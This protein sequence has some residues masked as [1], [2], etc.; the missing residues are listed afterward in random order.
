MRFTVSKFYI[1][2]FKIFVLLVFSIILFQGCLP[3]ENSNSSNGTNAANS[4]RENTNSMTD[5]NAGSTN[6]ASPY[7]AEENLSEEQVEQGRLNQ[8]WKKF[9]QLDAPTEKNQTQNTE[10]WSDV[11][12]EKVNNQKQ[13][14]PLS[15]DAQGPSVFR[16]QLLLDRTNF[17]PGIMDGKWGKN[18][19][20]AVYWLQKSEG[21]PAHGQVDRQTYERM[22]QLAG[23]P[24]RLVVEY[25]LTEKDVKGPFE[26]IPGDI[27][28]KAKMDCMCYESLE[29]QLA[30]MFHVSPA[31]LK[32]LNSKVTLN[33]LKAGDSI[34]V[35]NLP[36]PM[37]PG[38]SKPENKPDKTVAR[39]VVSDG[40]HYVHGLDSQGKLVVH[41]PSTLGSEYNP[42]P[43]G[44]YSITAI[45]HDP[46]WHYQP[47]LLGQGKGQD[48]MIPPGPN[49]AVGVIWMDLSKPHFGIHGT[50]APETIGYTTSSGCVRLTNWDA[51]DLGARI[52]KGTPVEFRDTANR[53]QESENSVNQNTRQ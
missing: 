48:A 33:D 11:T 21:L 13:Y 23:N 35:P 1:G 52:Q 36:S 27:Y 28:E 15:G 31:L 39:I 2:N 10:K 4:T 45:A 3:P 25:K 16:A 5:A 9:V 42:S 47:E 12:P 7:G 51:L 18:T 19:E 6:G 26:K 29:E 43:S 50:S 38:Q 34:T 20:K 49:N 8:D 30:E 37:I 14:T 53:S 24:D 46:A 44:E 22:I 40:G 17:S 32:Q 41:Y